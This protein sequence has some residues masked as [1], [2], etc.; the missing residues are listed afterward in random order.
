[1]NDS[2]LLVVFFLFLLLTILPALI[3]VKLFQY[4][5][6]NIFI[7]LILSIVIASVIVY[8]ILHLLYKST[9]RGLLQ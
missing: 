8:L 2:A 5:K 6:V 1:M 7:K 4:W 3:T 9:G